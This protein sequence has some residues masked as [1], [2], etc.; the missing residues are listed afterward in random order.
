MERRN[1]IISAVVLLGLGAA[2]GYSVSENSRDV[3]P[4]INTSMDTRMKALEQR[5]E[6]NEIGDCIN[7]GIARRSLGAEGIDMEG[8]TEERQG[9]QEKYWE[10]LGEGNTSG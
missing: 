8:C 10:T 3:S 1:T 4:N 6:M 9:W 7:E 5:L 2:A